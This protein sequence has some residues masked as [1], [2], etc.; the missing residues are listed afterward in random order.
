M[1]TTYI[2][3]RFCDTDALGH[4]NNNVYSVWFEESRE[5]VFRIFNPTLTKK[6]WNLIMASYSVDFLQEVFYGTKVKI[7]TTVEKIGTSSF[8]LKHEL[9]QHDKLC[10]IG[11]TTLVHFDFVNKKAISMDETLRKKLQ[12]HI[13]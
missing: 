4:I 7:D 10:T 12:E 1:L 9:Y 8:T 3:P 5:E 11:H 6:D 2:K 13:N